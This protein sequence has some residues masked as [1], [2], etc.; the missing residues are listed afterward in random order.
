[1]LHDHRPPTSQ[2]LTAA[3]AV[4]LKGKSAPTPRPYPNRS[5]EPYGPRAFLLERMSDL[6][7]EAGDAY[8]TALWELQ[9]RHC[10]ASLEG[11][12][13]RARRRLVPGTGAHSGEVCHARPG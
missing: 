12:R 3:E 7:G 8:A 5:P 11:E 4:R 6:A 2:T 1:M 13:V 9:W 10:V